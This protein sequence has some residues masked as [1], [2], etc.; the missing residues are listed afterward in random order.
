MVRVRINRVGIYNH[1]WEVFHND[2]HYEARIRCNTRE[3][4][5]DG[6]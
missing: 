5:R 3:M 6:I 4:T 1:K 2:I